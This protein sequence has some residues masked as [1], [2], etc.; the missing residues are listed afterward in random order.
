MPGE[1]PNRAAKAPNFY[2]LRH[3]LRMPKNLLQAAPLL[4]F[5]P[6]PFPPTLCCKLLIVKGFLDFN[7]LLLSKQPS[8]AAASNRCGFCHFWT[9][10]L[11]ELCSGSFDPMRRLPKFYGLVDAHRLA[12]A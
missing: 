1:A 6:P 9:A 5:N 2:G 7:S 11:I 12:L 10:H 4:A 8:K 3:G